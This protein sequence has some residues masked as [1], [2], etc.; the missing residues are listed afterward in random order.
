MPRIL[1]NLLLLVVLVAS[2]VAQALCSGGD[3]CTGLSLHFTLTESTRMSPNAKLLRF[4]LP[5]GRKTL[6]D[7]D[8]APSGVL[9]HAKI[10]DD[11]LEKSYS[12]VSLPSAEG[13]FELLVKEY[14]PR[15]GGGLGAHLCGLNNGDSIRMSVKIPRQIH[16]S[17]H[18]SGRWKKLGLV[19]GGTGMAPMIQ[20]MRFLLARPD[21]QTE[22]SV[23]SINRYEEDILMRAE[24]D[25]LAKAHPARLHVTYCLTQP[26][27]SWGGERGRGTVDLAYKVLPTANGEASGQ[28]M[29]MVCGTDGFVEHWAGPVLRETDPSTGKMRKVQGPLGGILRDAGYAESQVTCPVFFPPLC[30]VTE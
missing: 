26:S 30:C 8:V 10:G 3:T 20:M 11:E 19:G 28:T 15:P 23:L 18:I 27:E 12:P 7:P 16:G 17:E 1:A 13:F 9:A 24:I 5:D 2:Q 4:A 22:I 14:P 25:Q 29:I 21:D 6:A